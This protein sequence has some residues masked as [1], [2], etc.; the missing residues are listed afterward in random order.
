M[1]LNLR[2]DRQ[3]YTEQSTMGSL[4]LD[5]VF[6]CYTLEPPRREG[7]VKPRCISPGMFDVK[8]RYSEKHKRAMPHVENVPDFEGIEIHV[9]NTAKDTLACL[10]VGDSLGQD[11]VG[12][13]KQA[14]D[15]LFDILQKAQEKGSSI[16]ITYRDAE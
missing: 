11:F 13:S 15:R 10:L 4:L 2:V 3:A 16:Y 7:D 1:N 12:E 9:G 6:F 5:G 8:I 14:F